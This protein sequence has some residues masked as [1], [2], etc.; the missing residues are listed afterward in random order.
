MGYITIIVNNY[1]HLMVLPDIK[2]ILELKKTNAIGPFG[3]QPVK[4]AAT[5]NCCLI[6]TRDLCESPM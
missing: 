5:I 1:H 3:Q 2:M 4:P 6:A